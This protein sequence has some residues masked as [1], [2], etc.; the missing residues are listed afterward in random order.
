MLD[1][2]EWTTDDF[3]HLSWHDYQHSPVHFRWR[4]PI[5]WPSGV[6]TFE[7]PGFTQS[8]RAA[9]ILI[10]RQSLHPHER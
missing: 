6:I 2:P 3:E 5:N 1:K 8:L 10:D 9:P 4:L 7:S